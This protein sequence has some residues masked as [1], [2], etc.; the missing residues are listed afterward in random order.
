MWKGMEVVLRAD[1]EPYRD[2]FAVQGLS[3]GTEYS[4]QML[5]Y[6]GLKMV[7]HTRTVVTKAVN[8]DCL[9]VFFSYNSV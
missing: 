9:E 1:F 4:I 7:Q 6:D 8:G 5:A 2:R 3:P